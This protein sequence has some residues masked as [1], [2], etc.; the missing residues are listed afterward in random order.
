MF[1]ELSNWEPICMARWNIATCSIIDGRTDEQ[2]AVLPMFV[3][4]NPPCYRT[5]GLEKALV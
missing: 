3:P 2:I 4:Y 1:L 5:N